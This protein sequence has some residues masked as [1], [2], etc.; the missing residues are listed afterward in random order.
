MI[1]DPGSGYHALAPLD[2]ARNLSDA[3]ADAARRARFSTKS[4]KF[5]Q[6]GFQGRKNQS[7]FYWINIFLFV[8]MVVIPGLGAAIYFKGLASDQY[9]S[10]FRFTVSGSEIPVGDGISALTGI[11]ALS[12][13][14]DTQIV[15]NFLHTRAAVEQIDQLVN[16]REH[17]SQADIDFLTRFDRDKP[18]EELLRYWRSVS[19]I[20]IQMPSGIVK[21][22]VRAFDPITAQKIANAILEVSERLVNEMNDRMNRDTLALAESELK[23][24]AERLSAARLALQK[25]RNS[26]GYIDIAKAIDGVNK[27]ILERRSTLLS[28]EQEYRTNLRLVNEN[29]PQMQNL[30]ARIEIQNRQLKE[31]EAQLTK[32]KGQPGLSETLTQAISEF[33]ELELER[34]IS[35]RIYTTAITGL[36]LARINAERKKMYLN[37]FIKP[38]VAEEPRYPR[39]NLSLFLVIL[40]G[41][42]LWGTLVGIIAL[43]RNHMA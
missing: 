43:I 8:V 2:R 22:E 19:S 13:I 30:R 35:E 6:G 17:Y 12:I 42:A 7:A 38:M 15:A 34:Q 32:T 27:L 37:A 23:R 20:A 31:L 26:S 41:L 24:A 40:S 29:A 39:R 4:R 14:Q 11:P 3:F 18:I 1:G 28:L 33:S 10:E 25:I 5:V 16:L 9:V 21:T 36:E